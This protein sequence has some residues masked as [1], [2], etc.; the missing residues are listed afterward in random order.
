[1]KNSTVIDNPIKQRYELTL[2]GHTAVVDYLRKP[3]RLILTHTG[4]PSPLEGRGV[5]SRLV[6]GV[7]ED[8]RAKGLRVVSQCT[9]ISRYIERHPEWAEIT[10]LCK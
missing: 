6:Q 7:L 8:A 9:F 2:E 10:D 4:V 3:G 5:G 1:M